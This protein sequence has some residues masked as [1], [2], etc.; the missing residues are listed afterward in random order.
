MNTHACH[1]DFRSFYLS[2]DASPDHSL[3]AFAKI[4][5]D[6]REW[7]RFQKGKLPSATTDSQIHAIVQHAIRARLDRY[8]Q[9]LSVSANG[10][11]S[12]DRPTLNLW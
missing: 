6:D 8:P 11:A 3:V 4:L 7:K 10:I 5:L 12:H 2:F 9:S 1:S